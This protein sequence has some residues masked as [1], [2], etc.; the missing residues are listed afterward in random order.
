MFVVSVS[1][2]E[3]CDRVYNL[4]VDGPPEFYANGILV[5]N[6]MDAARYLIVG[7]DR[8][9]VAPP[10]AREPEPAKPSAGRDIDDERFWN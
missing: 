8:G 9:K 7:L 3:A 10:P 4:T 2:S 5:H 6:C 1:D